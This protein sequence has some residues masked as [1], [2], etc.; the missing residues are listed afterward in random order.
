M[1]ALAQEVG[2]VEHALRHLHQFEVFVHGGFAQL[3]VGGVLA[4][5][6][7]LHQELFGLV[8]GF[9]VLDRRAE[10][11]EFVAGGGQL[12]AQGLFVLEA[13]QGYVQNRANA[14]GDRPA[15]M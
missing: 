6:L 10:F 8:D 7:A 14:S 4:E 3:G 9:A 15:T 13:G 12:L 2:H 1:S 5:F 11:I